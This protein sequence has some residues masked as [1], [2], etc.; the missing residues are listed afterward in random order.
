MQPAHLGFKGQPK[1][2]FED[3]LSL[4]LVVI[5]GRA[6]NLTNQL[7]LSVAR[8]SKQSSFAILKG[9]AAGC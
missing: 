6:T 1:T 8:F 5:I 4:R 2:D 9:I 7:M 3:T